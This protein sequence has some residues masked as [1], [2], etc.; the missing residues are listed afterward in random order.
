MPADF[1]YYQ[2]NPQRL[3]CRTWR[4]FPAFVAT[5]DFGNDASAESKEVVKKEPKKYVAEH[6]LRGLAK[7]GSKGTASSWTRK[8]EVEGYDRLYFDLHG[9]GDLADAKPIDAETPAAGPRGIVVG[10]AQ[11]TFPRVDLAVDVAG[12]KLDHSFFF[13]VVAYGRAARDGVASLASA[14]YR[15][16]EIPWTG[17]SGR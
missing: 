13:Q 9:D 16:G 8:Q 17:R 10:Y 12:K 5:T 11:T 14:V 1:R 6:P 2:V 7:L 3:L 4:Y 15:R